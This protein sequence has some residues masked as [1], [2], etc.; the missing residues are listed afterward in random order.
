MPPWSVPADLLVP[1]T[2]VVGDEDLLVGRAVTAVVR[3]ARAASPDVDVRDVT[4]AELQ[5]GDLDDML[6]PSL[7]GESRVL[8][9]RSAQDLVKEVAAELTA[10]VAD[11]LE[12]VCVVVHHAGGAKGKALLTALLA[13]RPRKV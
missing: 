12:D 11:P 9:V 10:Y 8:V 7:F 5:R 2:V 1:L 4:G 13:T 3:A 6:S